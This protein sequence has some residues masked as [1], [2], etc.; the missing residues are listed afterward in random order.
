M[1]FTVGNIY[2]DTHQLDRALSAYTRSSELKSDSWLPVFGAAKVYFEMGNKDIGAELYE[3][4]FTNAEED[5]RKSVLR[6][7][8]FEPFRQY[9]SQTGLEKSDI[10][11]GP[12][13]EPSDIENKENNRNHSELLTD[14]TTKR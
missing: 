13:E 4:A 11:G 12:E 3:E 7:E 6:D 14:I 9:E 2:Y 5:V 10:K 1:W 8:E